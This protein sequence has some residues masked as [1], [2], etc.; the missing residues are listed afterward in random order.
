MKKTIKILILFLITASLLGGCTQ[1][2]EL[3]ILMYHN[4]VIADEAT[5]SLSITREHFEN[6]LH[7]LLDNGYTTV[8]PSEV[9]AM[10]A[11]EMPWPEKPIL[12]TF[13]DGYYSNYLYAYPLLAQ[14]DMKAVINVQNSFIKQ[15]RHIEPEGDQIAPLTWD[16]VAEMASSGYIEIG[17]HTYDLHNRKLGGKISYQKGYP[18]GIAKEANETLDH[19][20][21]RISDDIAQ[22]S[23][24]ITFYTGQPVCC[25]A[26]PYGI[27]NR[28]AAIII[29]EQ[30]IPITFSTIPKVAKP[31][32][33]LAKMPRFAVTMDMALSDILE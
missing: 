31:E 25:F 29:A 24:E 13:D 22:S 11:G 33:C 30:G 20:K 21:Q 9:L 18:N 6:D 10:V 8:L 5:S 4:I 32:R 12:I 3:P 26:Y 23:E 17:S 2:H 27:T 19:Y 14:N 15:K 28:V 7:Y 1:E 16:E